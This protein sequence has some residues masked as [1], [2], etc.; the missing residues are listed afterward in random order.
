[1]HDCTYG[2][3]DGGTDRT[4]TSAVLRRVYAHP[5]LFS[6]IRQRS[7]FFRLITLNRLPSLY[8]SNVESHNYYE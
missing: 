7:L 1:M 6:G 3:I 4:M 2:I 8:W 5:I